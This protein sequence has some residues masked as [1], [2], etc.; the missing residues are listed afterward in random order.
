MTWAGFVCLWTNSSVSLLWTL[1][2]Y[3][4]VNSGQFLRQPRFSSITTFQGSFFF[5]FLEIMLRNLVFWPITWGPSWLTGRYSVCPRDIFM[6]SRFHRGWVWS[7]LSRNSATT[8]K[9]IVGMGGGVVWRE[10]CCGYHFNLNSGAEWL[11]HPGFINSS[12]G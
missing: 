11:H 6:P 3:V 8:I 2:N 4:S 9:Q 10:D 1:T 7:L 5:L 12:A